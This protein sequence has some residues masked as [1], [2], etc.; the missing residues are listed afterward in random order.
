MRP[1]V[2]VII[3]NWNGLDY[4]GPCLESLR[5]QSFTDSETIVVDNGSTDGSVA[6]LEENFPEVTVI[7]LDENRGFCE[8]NNVGIRRA[9]GD[10]VALLNNDTVVDSDWLAALVDAAESTDAEFFA[11]KILLHDERDLVDT[12]GD[13][14]SSLGVAG[15]RGH[16]EDAHKYDEQEEVFGACAGAVLYRKEM[17]DDVGLFDE[18]LFLSYED[19]DLSFRARLKGY[20]AVFVPDAVVYHHLSS[21]IGEDSSTYVYYGQ[22]NLEYVFIKNLPTRLLVRY[23]PLHII[24]NVL[25]FVYFTWRGR[26]RAFLSAKY[27]ALKAIPVL[28]RKRRRIQNERRVQTEDIRAHI[29]TGGLLSKIADKLTKQ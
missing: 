10:Y 6:F 17:L 20:R 19:V 9:N 29:R 2:S 11:S 23:L 5:E 1:T 21:T 16:L 15:K 24:Y 26:G 8:A 27:D 22:R 18:D 7:E 13:Y 14:Y 4:L 25:A 12:C 3:V 28:L